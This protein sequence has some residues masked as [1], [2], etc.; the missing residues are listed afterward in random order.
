M[1][2]NTWRMGEKYVERSALVFFQC[3]Q[4]LLNHGCDT[5]IQDND[6][7]SAEQLALKSSQLNT[8]RLLRKKTAELVKCNKYKINKN[9][10]LAIQYTATTATHRDGI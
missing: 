1:I 9:Y 10:L 7:L 2:T 4:F 6:G 5:N 3:V 8:V